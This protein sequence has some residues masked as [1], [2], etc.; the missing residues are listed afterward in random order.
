MVVQLV[1]RGC[2]AEAWL[3]GLPIARGTPQ[4]PRVVVAAHEAALV[5]T[6]RLELIVG[7]DAAAPGAAAL[8]KTAPEAMAAQLH[9]LL[10]RIG[11]PIEDSQSRLLA[12]IE[13]A[14]A[15]GDAFEFPA[16]QVR[17]V[18][19]PLRLPRWRWLDAPIVPQTP[20]LPQ[21]V[22]TFVSG[23][24]RDLTRGQTESFIAATRLRTE[25]L[26]IA[27]QRDPE[28]ELARLREWLEQLYASSR[29]IWQPLVLEEMHLRRVAGGRLV[30]CL[31]PGGR[32][33]LATVPDKSATVLALPLRL[34]L[35][36]GRFYVLR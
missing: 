10:P 9:L 14:C 6:N 12:R 15:V 21:Q 24:A 36:E 1:V 27:Y 22:H 11:A 20:T 18:D 26:A 28:T 13:W 30:E 3:N 5:G 32:A 19:L 31:G 29:L 17:D 2:T 8:L 23:L 25:E 35:V 34:S 7:P 33:A 16:R 4:A